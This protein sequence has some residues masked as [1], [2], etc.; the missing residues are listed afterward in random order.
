MKT[1]IVALLF[2]LLASAFYAHAQ[3]D[4]EILLAER[5][6]ADGEF[7]EALELY[8]KLFK[9]S[10][11]ERYAL[12][13]VACYSELGQFE[14]ATSYLDKLIKKNDGIAMYPI[15]KAGILEKTGDL[16]GAEGIYNQVI[17]K[18]LKTEGDFVKIGSYLNKMGKLEVAGNVYRQ[19]RKRLKTDYA[20]ANELA[21]IYGQQGEFEKATQEYL[22]EYYANPAMYDKVKIDILNL[23]YPASQD[24]VERGLLQA[25]DRNQDDAGLRVLLFEFYVLSKNFRESFIQVKSIDRLF[26][27]DGNRVF[28]FAQTL[29]NSKQYDLSNDA[30]SYLIDRKGKDSP[31]YFRAQLEKAVNSELKA[32]DQLPV[33]MTAVEEA[34][35]NYESMLSEFGRNPEYFNAI[36][37]QAKLQ[38]FY[39]DQL[40]KA[41]PNLADIASKPGLKRDQ[42]A[43]AKLLVGDILLMKKNYNEARL[44]YDEV[45]KAFKDRQTGALAK[46]K[47]AQ[48]L[49]YKGEFQLSQATLTAIKDNTSNDISNDAIRLN[50]TIMDNS[51]MDTTTA[52]LERF[53]EAQ[54][55]VYQRDY[56]EA[57]IKLDSL[58]EAFPGHNLTDE[59]LWE[60]TNIY[61]K[62]NDIDKAMS[63]IERILENHKED[64]YADDALYTKARLYDY[65]LKNPEM[66]SKLYLEFLT[67][68]PGSLYSVE[69]R[70]RLRALRQEG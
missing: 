36:F 35:D 39:S 28:A 30:F 69:V 10:G 66:A 44:A 14:E 46:F 11:A 45:V 64:I 31:Y 23:V 58:A 60:K 26:Q 55:L 51:G 37:R 53:A 18:Q 67:T 4:P 12:R 48:L 57:M 6:F 5:Y 17:K 34:I 16:K 29:R 70:K 22:H 47:L 62:R 13:A 8:Q 41:L 15:V 1:K 20:F 59:I 24:A 61:L 50:L 49:Y 65:N 43:D 21:N 3:D 27:E 54:L 42:W 38:V 52:P 63:Y 19:G 7:P 32:F 40:D 33:D 9:K 56:D 68:F 2:C 25:V